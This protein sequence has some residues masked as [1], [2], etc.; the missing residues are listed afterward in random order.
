MDTLS[1]F[2]MGA[3]NRGREMKVFDWVRAAQIIAERNP[4]EA[5]AGLSSDMEWTSGPI[6]R[7]GLPVPK[8]DTYTYLASTW[9]TPV[10]EIDGDEISCFRMESETPNWDAHTYWPDEARAVL[11]VSEA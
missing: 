2:A 3:A 1:A 9:A 8:E 6:W 10:L 7:N 5:V 11:G 4:T